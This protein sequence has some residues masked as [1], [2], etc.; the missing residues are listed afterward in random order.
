MVL[1]GEVPLR[2]TVSMG[3]R[4]LLVRTCAST[5]LTTQDV[6]LM[7]VSDC[8]PMLTVEMLSVAKKIG[9]SARRSNNEVTDIP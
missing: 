6:E 4:V 1:T 2:A 8:G 7:S 5:N 3:G 9:T